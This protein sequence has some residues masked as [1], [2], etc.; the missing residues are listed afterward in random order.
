MAK[1]QNTGKL[2]AKSASAPAI[3]PAEV[4][5]GDFPDAM[6]YINS[7][8]A[9]REGVEWNCRVYQILSAGRGATERMPYLYDVQLEDLPEQEARLGNEYPGGGSFRVAVRMNNA[10]LKN[11]RLDIAPRP[12]YKA[13]APAWQVAA[14]APIAEAPQTDRLESIFVRMAEMQERSAQQTRDLIA[15]LMAARPASASSTLN[16]QLEI[17]TKFQAMIPKGQQESTQQSFEKGME[18]AM[19]IVEA[20]GSGGDGGMDWVGLAKEALSSPLIKDMLASMATAAQAGQGQQPQP[21][22]ASPATASPESQQAAQAIDM[23]L[24]QAAAGVDPKFTAAQVWQLVPAAF[25]EE[26]EAQDDVAGYLIAKFPQAA[27]H[28]AWLERLVA[29]LWEPEQSASAPTLA[30][31]NAPDPVQP[32]T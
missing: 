15:G 32:S 23:L 18:F 19:K 29:E 9:S 14:A 8:A 28:R 1:R 30:P 27:P 3:A 21:L 31:V 10:L 25:M 22:I 13:P 5:T 26:L 6:S 16:E 2:T 11:I 7:L 4:E 12:G 24:S 20:R 17:F